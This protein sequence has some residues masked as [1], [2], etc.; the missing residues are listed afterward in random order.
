MPSDTAPHVA[1]LTGRKVEEPRSKSEE[2]KIVVSAPPLVIDAQQAIDFSSR[3]VHTPQAVLISKHA[4]SL[5][6]DIAAL[7]AD[8]RVRMGGAGAMS[9]ILEAVGEE[10]DVL[11]K[12]NLRVK[13]R[14]H[15]TVHGFETLCRGEIDIF[16]VARPILKPEMQICGRAGVKFIELPVAYEA[17]AVIVNSKAAWISEITTDELR[18]MWEPNAQ[19]RVVRWNHVNDAWPDQP[20]QLFGPGLGSSLHEY[21]TEAIVGKP[22]ITTRV[23]YLGTNFHNFVTNGVSRYSGAIGFVRYASEI[24]PA[25][26]VK[27]LKIVNSAGQAVSPSDSAFVDAS[28]NP[29]SRPLFIYVNAERAKK[30]EVSAFVKFLLMQGAKSIGNAGGIPLPVDMYD[31]ALAKFASGK[32]GTVFDGKSAIGVQLDEALAGEPVQ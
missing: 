29:L 7:P 22:K 18:K 20:L 1:P 9:A 28:Y 19:A 15:G 26:Q 16:G 12:G 17:V 14:I 3:T 11:T 2:R 31:S 4:Q 10:F 5:N 8:S 6:V 32:P 25:S 21:F 30:P 24:V 23:D 27:A 13:I